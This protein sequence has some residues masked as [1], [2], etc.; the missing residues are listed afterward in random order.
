MILAALLE[1][2]EERALVPTPLGMLAEGGLG[3]PLGCPVGRARRPLAAGASDE[4]AEEV[5]LEEARREVSRPPDGKK[6]ELSGF[7]E[8]SP[9]A[10][11]DSRTG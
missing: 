7:E 10:E 1:G 8:D 3:L 2:D 6:A 5:G 9:T 4:S 11:L